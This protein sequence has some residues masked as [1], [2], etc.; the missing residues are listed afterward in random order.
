MQKRRLWLLLG[1]LPLVALTPGELMASAQLQLKVSSG[2]MTVSSPVLASPG[3]T[4]L[5]GVCLGTV[6]THHACLSGWDVTVDAGNTQGTVLNPSTIINPFMSEA[7]DAKTITTVT[8]PLTIEVS[9]TGFTGSL[10]GVESLLSEQ[11]GG[12][13]GSNVAFSVFYNTSNTLFPSLGNHLVDSYT[14]SSGTTFDNIALSP[15]APATSPYTLTLVAV[16]SASPA[17][18][19]SSFSM[20]ESAV[21]EP[22]FYGVLALGLGGMILAVQRKRKAASKV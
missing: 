22:G 17:G 16:I 10:T 11:F 13:N 1:L 6:G 9:A 2:S 14:G 4:S 8:N 19:E 3:S 20:M 7:A 5:V 12:P 18:Q 21:P 15:L